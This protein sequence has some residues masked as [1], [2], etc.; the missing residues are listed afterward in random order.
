[1]KRIPILVLAALILSLTL[2]ASLGFGG[3]DAAAQGAP[4]VIGVDG[5]GNV[6]GEPVLVH[7]LAVVHPGENA[8]AV[9]RAVLAAQGA[10]PFTSA[11][12]S[13]TG[14]DWNDDPGDVP[15]QVTVTQNYN[16]S[17]APT[18]SLA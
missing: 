3:D 13:L 11:D 14:L 1:M 17:N 2:G 8:A 16:D 5:V 4:Q 12:F 9:A 18:A 7:I 15:G 6:G 10:R